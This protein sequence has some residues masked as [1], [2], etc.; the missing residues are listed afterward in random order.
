MIFMEE[1]NVMRA[2]FPEIKDCHYRLSS[3]KA[4]SFNLNLAI[5]LTSGALCCCEY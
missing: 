4:V 5:H 1:K 3:R 2:S